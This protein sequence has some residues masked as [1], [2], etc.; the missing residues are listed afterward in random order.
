MI[1]QKTVLI[2]GAN[3]GIGLEI[4]HQLG[5]KGFQVIL[6]GRNTTSG[7]TAV[8]H[9]KSKNIDAYWYTLDLCDPK[10]IESAFLKVSHQ[11]DRLDVLVNNGGVLVNENRSILKP[12]PEEDLLS[13]KTN[14]LGALWVTQ[15]FMPLLKPGSRVIMI[16]S[17]A[18]KFNNN[19]STW[20]PHYRISKTL[21]NA[22]T[23]QLHLSLANNAVIINSVCPGWVRTQMGGQNAARSIEKGAETPVWL[24][25]EASPT[26]NGKLLRDKQEIQW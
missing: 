16:S 13:V 19:T 23:K 10:S 7:K 8:K 21:M 26:I 12:A 1:N 18:G 14:A 22:I 15:Y 20:A 6:T 25:T 3:R 9:L 24:A 2:T 11:V 17:G 4:G 5:Q